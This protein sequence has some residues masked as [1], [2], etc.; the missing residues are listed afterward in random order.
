[1]L[2]KVWN[3]NDLEVRFRLQQSRRGDL[4]NVSV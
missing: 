1:M 3:A 2:G 4:I